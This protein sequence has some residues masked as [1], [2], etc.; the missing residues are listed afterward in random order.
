GQTLDTLTAAFYGSGEF[1]QTRGRGRDDAFVQALYLDLLDRTPEQAG[2]AA[3]QGL[4]RSGVSRQAV[5][6]A[7]LASPEGLT[8]EIGQ[9]YSW[10][11]HRPADPAGLAA[12][13]AA[14]AQGARGEE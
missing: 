5:A 13:R 14:R 2:L 6:Q 8:E 9:L 1:Y 12:F 11:L 7:V 10:L 3:W 4:L